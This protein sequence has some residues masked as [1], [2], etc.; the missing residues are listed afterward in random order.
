[1]QTDVFVTHIGPNCKYKVKAAFFSGEVWKDF[2]V[3]FLNQL[4]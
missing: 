4:Q 2:G 3:F 1:M